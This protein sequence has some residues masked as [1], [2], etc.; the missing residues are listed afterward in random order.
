MI[1]IDGVVI[2]N[3]R[4]GIMGRDINRCFNS[5]DLFDE[6]KLIR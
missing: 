2:G 3:F 1:N 6:V 5:P 4:T